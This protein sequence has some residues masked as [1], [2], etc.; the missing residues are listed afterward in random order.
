MGAGSN[1]VLG[2]P[3]E[4]VRLGDHSKYKPMLSGLAVQAERAG[5]SAGLGLPAFLSV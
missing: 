3:G 4:E 1:S 2:G 5:T